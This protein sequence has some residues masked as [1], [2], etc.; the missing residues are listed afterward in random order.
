MFGNRQTC[1]Q[2]GEKISKGANFCGNCGTTLAGGVLRCG[3]CGVEN[4]GDAS[5][6]KECG[7]SLSSS[8]APVMRNHRWARNDDDFAVRIDADDV[9]GFLKHGLIVDLGT[10][11]LLVD[12]GE[13]VGTVAPGEYSLDSFG[14]R[15]KELFAGRIPE[16]LT[17]LLVEITP[18]EFEFNLGGIFTSDP[19]R[20]GA[21]VRLQAEVAFPGKFLV[22]M[23]KGNER[24]SKEALRQHLYPEVVQVVER[25]VR[26]H[27]LQELAEDFKLKDRLELLL[28]ETLKTTF[29][30]LGLSF[31]NIRVLELNMEHLE[32][33]LDDQQRVNETRRVYALQ[34]TEA[35]AEAEGRKH[36]G[37]AQRELDLV[38][39]AEE[40][41][42]VEMDEKRVAI[43]QRMREAVMSDR[44]NEITSEAE[45]TQFL[46]DMDYDNLLREKER[47]ELLRTWKE[48]AKDHEM[49][50][51][52]LLAKL[53]VEQTYEVNLLALKL[54]TEYDL[55]KFESEVNIARKRADFEW[56][57]KRKNV[58]EELWLQREEIRIRDE[59][60]RLEAERKHWLRQQELKDDV[61]EA[62]AGIRL[63]ALMKETRR[64]D[65]EEN[66]RID[67][68]HELALL[69]AKQAIE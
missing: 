55:K 37:E 23:L 11:A 44:M 38:K 18:T 39:L 35:E 56:E 20:I 36:I 42:E 32:R 60:E 48:D 5:F 67:R 30:Q 57:M 13:V 53:E 43:H 3:A 33:I 22:N 8:A 10:N 16:N 19:L 54:S 63:L 50:R 29:A 52:H 9:T 7:Q 27:T 21:T 17:A 47:E 40:T 14:G 25:W 12:K 58:E 64:L 45:F 6:C 24:I 68:E 26:K 61:A 51:A 1:P 4:R 59:R 46:H 69:K 2:C 62:E 15:L 66:N 34:V 41:R 28:D 31:L 65:K 49:A